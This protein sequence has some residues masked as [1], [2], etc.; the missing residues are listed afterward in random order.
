MGSI[1]DT[2]T[3]VPLMSGLFNYRVYAYTQIEL[4]DIIRENCQQ[5]LK[6]SLFATSA[7]KLQKRRTVA[8]PP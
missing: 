3:K 4:L 8:C 6:T 1:R 7:V 2:P 5:R